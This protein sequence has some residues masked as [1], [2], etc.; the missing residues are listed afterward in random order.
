[1]KRTAFINFAGA[2]IRSNMQEAESDPSTHEQ[3]EVIISIIIDHGYDYHHKM[4]NYM[5]CFLNS[6]M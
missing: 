6:L 3:L 5:F 4:L 1:M 2:L